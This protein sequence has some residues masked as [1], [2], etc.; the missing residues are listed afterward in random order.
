MLRTS[1]NLTEAREKRKERREKQLAAHHA[2]LVFFNLS[3]YVSS[4]DYA[5]TKRFVAL[6]PAELPQ[7]ILKVAR[8]RLFVAFQPKQSSNFVAAGIHSRCSFGCCAG[9]PILASAG[10]QR[11]F[12]P[13][14]FSRHR[15]LHRLVFHFLIMVPSVL[16]HWWLLTLASARSTGSSSRTRVAFC[17]SL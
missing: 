12:F 5:S 13:G 6:P 14:N 8:R 1:K 4:S 9:S 7:E 16:I 2:P 3:F 15:Q 10:C 11:R 17:S